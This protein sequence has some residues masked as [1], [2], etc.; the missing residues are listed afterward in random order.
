MKIRVGEV[1]GKSRNHGKSRWPPSL[2]MTK[3]LPA[4][5][6]RDVEREGNRERQKKT[7]RS[8]EK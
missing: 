7:Q 6:M 4:M 3:K 1:G 2:D 8:R 5:H